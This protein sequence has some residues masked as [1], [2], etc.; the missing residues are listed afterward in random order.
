M[1]K[2]TYVVR[3]TFLTKFAYMKAFWFDIVGT[4]V[5][6]IIYYFLWQFVFAETANINGFTAEEMTTYLIFSRILSSQ[7]S[8]GINRE[9]G[10]WIYDGTIS[11]E[12]LRPYFLIKTLFAKRIGEFLFFVLFKAIPI[13]AINIIVLK[14][15]G[16]KNIVN[17][18][19]FLISVM[20]SIV[21]MFL[22]ECMVGLLSFYTLSDWGLTFTKSAV[23]SL[24][25]GGIVPIF[26][27]PRWIENILNCMPFAGMVSVPINIFLG[28]YNM[29]EIIK[30]LL[31]QIF[32]IISLEI[33]LYF[34]YQIAIK[35]VIIQGG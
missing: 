13:V 25:S 12:L 16:T 34:F 30:L 22:I 19:S 10:R 7:F 15:S 23:C 6:I 14:G 31:F 8:D 24:L 32:W 20:A 11:I 27:F 2:F 26:L 35:N 5:S 18:M 33:L 4:M 21:L 28:K 3:L 1:K 9:M 29:E 17:I